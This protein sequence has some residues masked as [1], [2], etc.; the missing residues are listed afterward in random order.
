MLSFAVPAIAAGDGGELAAYVRARAADGDR[1]GDRAAS[2]YARALAA[3]P[4]NV[5]IAIRAYRAGL[6]A[7]DNALVA[8]A[9]DVLERASVEPGDTALLALADAVRR[10]NDADMQ[11]ALARIAAGPL[12]FVATP[13]RAW[14]L[15]SSDPKRALALVDTMPRRSMAA[16]FTTEARALIALAGGQSRSGLIAVEA[17][18]AANPDDAELRINAAHLLYQSGAKDEALALLPARDPALAAARA[19][20]GTVVPALASF[21]IARFYTRLGG[22]IV[23]DDTAPLAIVLARAAL[24]LD[25][26]YDPARLVLGKA[27]ASEGAIDSALASLDPIR[28]GSPWF[29]AQQLVR[30]AILRRAGRTPDALA[31]AAPLAQ[32]PD[33]EVATIQREGDLL[34]ASERFADAAASYRRAISRAGAQADWVL[35]L[36]AGSALDRAGR[37]RDAR[38]LIEKSVALAPD[39]AVALNYLGYGALENGG[40][41]GAARKLLERA[42]ALKPDDASILD[43]LGWSYLLGGD[44]ARALPLLEHAAANLPD[45]ATISDHLGDAYWRVGRRFEARYAWSAARVLADESDRERIADKI[46]AGL[47]AR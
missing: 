39:E 9:R 37:W 22:D 16:R 42:A 29:D 1:R 2:D 24:A 30:I 4:G 47:S 33:A 40:D 31:I 27:L 12:D 46:A 26:G 13:L 36:Q 15:V 19:Q 8:R 14:T 11:A 38:P 45:N 28:P 43:S 41:V 6:Q 35:Y 5:V 34:M 17:L 7:G 44:V 20:L 32:L 25:P 18:L 23:D 3:S 10:N 21:G